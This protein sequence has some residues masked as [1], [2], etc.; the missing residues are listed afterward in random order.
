[1]KTKI[2]NLNDLLFEQTSDLYSAK[3]LQLQ[4]FPKLKAYASSVLLR[5]N[6]DLQIEEAKKHVKKL[7]GFF[8]GPKRVFMKEEGRCMER[9]IDES[10]TLTQRCQN[11]EV[12]DAAIVTA[13]QHMNHYNIAGYG[14]V[15]TYANELKL[16]KDATLLHD[17]LKGEKQLDETLSKAAM[18]KIN[19]SA[20]PA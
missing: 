13:I 12:R 19:L 11:E 7:D 15:S 8:D 5:K 10:I 16:A 2:E 14:A 4:A 20:I 17:L 6:I 3:K 1:M 9:L 18:E